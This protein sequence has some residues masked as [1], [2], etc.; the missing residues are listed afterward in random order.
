M[1]P[2]G[3]VG[4][5]EIVLALV[6][7]INLLVLAFVW[8]LTGKVK[9]ELEGQTNHVTNAIDNAQEAI[10]TDL[11]NGIRSRV[12]EIAHTVNDE[13]IPRLDKKRERLTV[14][15]EKVDKLSEKVSPA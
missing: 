14:V 4:A 10:Q 13:V 8:K 1:L 9:G 6:P 15:E 12:E 2:Y 3:E 11:K 7:T 5:G